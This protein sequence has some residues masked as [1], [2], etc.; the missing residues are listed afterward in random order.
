[1][2]RVV[3]DD[4]C[5]C[6]ERGGWS[7]RVALSHDCGDPRRPHNQPGQPMTLSL[8]G[9]AYVDVDGDQRWEW[10]DYPTYGYLRIAAPSGSRSSSDGR[11]ET[12]DTTGQT[13]VAATATVA[14]EYENP[15][16]ETAELVDTDGNRWAVSEVH[17]T[18][19]A[20]R[21][22]LQRTVDAE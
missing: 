11:S 6:T 14:W 17:T 9:V 16:T 13:R 18:I 8:R 3:L 5:S 10:V 12:N 1:M 2:A 19:G 4:P 15:V 20:L 22:S 7:A 21:L